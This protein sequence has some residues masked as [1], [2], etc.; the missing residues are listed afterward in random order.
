MLGTEVL[1]EGRAGRRR[2][3]APR[4]FA[5]SMTDPC[6]VLGRVEK[7]YLSPAGVAR[8]LPRRG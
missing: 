3:L 6:R 2:R 1:A 5:F 8:R 4:C 7:S